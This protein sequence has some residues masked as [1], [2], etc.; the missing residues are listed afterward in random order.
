MG[1][2][3]RVAVLEWWEKD[4]IAEVIYS[5]LQQ[6]RHQPIY[7]FH[8]E[9]IPAK[10]NIVMTFG[11]YGKLLP[12]LHRVASIPATS[13]PLLIHWDTEGIPNPK[14]PW[15]LLQYMGG[16]LAWSER[17]SDSAN[18]NLRK[19]ASLPPLSILNR[20]SFRIRLD[21]NY[22]YAYQKGWINIFVE[23][24]QIYA[25]INTLHGLPT[26]YV[27][28]G[29]HPNWYA[30]TDIERDIDVLWMGSRRSRR[31]MR[32]INTVKEVLNSK[33][34]KMHIIDG[35]E[36]PAVFEDERNIIFN[37]SKITLNILPAWYFNSFAFR[38]H[39]A[40]GNRTLV[41]SEPILPHCPIY[42][43]GI[44]YVSTKIN[45]M[46]DTIC[47]YL[48]N[49]HEREKIVEQAY[50]LVCQEMTFTNSIHMIMDIANHYLED[51][52]VGLSGNER[53]RKP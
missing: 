39:L 5:S 49:P 46:V 10:A 6:L 44:H 2:G 45:D 24:S 34:Y 15:W 19:L 26:Y 31:R 28:W 27:P 32:L 40:A 18:P 47:F 38:Y 25:R 3:Y 23:T 48:N 29:T 37:R 22:H 9:P 14:I 16:V 30:T 53:N 36:N 12:V 17:L 8:D 43:P 52:Q 21:G 50:Q 42:Q 1:G 33:G 20:T 7:F 41:I 51:Q 35:I 13:R 11:P 4:G